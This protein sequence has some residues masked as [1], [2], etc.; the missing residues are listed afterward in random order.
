MFD[1]LLHTNW[2][3][4]QDAHLWEKSLWTP[5]RNCTQWAVQIVKF[6]WSKFFELWYKRNEIIH[7]SNEQE[8][9]KLKMD[10]YKCVLETMYHLKDMLQTVDRHYMFQNSQEVEEFLQIWSIQYIQDYI[11]IWYPFFKR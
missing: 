5:W 8:R 4:I 9:T 6:L 1:R 3:N 11:T 10:R 7:I 2:A